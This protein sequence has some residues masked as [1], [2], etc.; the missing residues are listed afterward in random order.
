MAN[1]GNFTVFLTPGAPRGAWV[2]WTRIWGKRGAFL[3]HE[4]YSF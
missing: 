3:V 2:S 4:F 1:L